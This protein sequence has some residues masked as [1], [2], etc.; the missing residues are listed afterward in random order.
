[1]IFSIPGMKFPISSVSIFRFPLPAVSKG[2]KN[3][4]KRRNFLAT[5]RIITNRWND[6]KSWREDE[7]RSIVIFETNKSAEKE[8]KIGDN[9]EKFKKRKIIYIYIYTRWKIHLPRLVYRSSRNFSR[10]SA[11]HRRV[12]TICNHLPPLIHSPVSPPLLSLWLLQQFREQYHGH[13]ALLRFP[14]GMILLNLPL[15]F[16]QVETLQLEQTTRSFFSRERGLFPPSPR[17]LRN[18]NTFIWFNS[19]VPP[20][21]SYRI[22]L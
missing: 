3:R 14:R 11:N 5:F 7:N 15:S 2:S 9:T 13:E 4:K 20:L 8:R 17:G 16:R 12:K 10:N 21:L 22:F 18:G 6:W 19:C 1:M